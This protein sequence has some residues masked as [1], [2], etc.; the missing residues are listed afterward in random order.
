MSMTLCHT[1]VGYLISFV[2][3]YMLK[4]HFLQRG[5]RITNATPPPS[6]CYIC[7]QCLIA[8]LLI[9][10]ASWFCPTSGFVSSAGSTFLYATINRRPGNTIQSSNNQPAPCEYN[11]IKQQS[12]GALG[13]HFNQSP[14]TTGV[15]IN[16]SLW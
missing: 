6:L 15:Y 3:T 16:D 5:S 11:S 8:L 2:H 12:T 7:W 10:Q 9:Q 1:L 4:L 14:A 13:I